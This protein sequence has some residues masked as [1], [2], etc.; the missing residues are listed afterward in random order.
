M[1][2]NNQRTREDESYRENR[3]SNRIM[4]ALGREEET[5]LSME[6]EAI[7]EPI[8]EREI[9]VSEERDLGEEST[10]SV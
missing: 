8:D 9:E 3:L 1:R 4:R 2:R 5:L 7:P 10:Y 6:Y